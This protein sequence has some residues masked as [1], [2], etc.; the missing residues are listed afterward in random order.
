M[1]PSLRTGAACF[2]FS[3]WMAWTLTLTQTGAP[4]MCLLLVQEFLWAWRSGGG[5][6][7][8]PTLLHRLF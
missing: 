2:L 6:N 7:G 1:S 5:W 3:G 4:L 8:K